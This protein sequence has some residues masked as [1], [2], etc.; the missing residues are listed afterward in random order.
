MTGDR[1]L[2]RKEH[3]TLFTAHTEDVGNVVIFE[4]DVERVSIVTSAL[5]YLT[6]HVHIG[7]EMHFDLD[8][9][10]AGTRFASATGDVE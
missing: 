3:H 4:G 9:S 10:I 2:I 5:A 7:K 6:R 1:R 8:G